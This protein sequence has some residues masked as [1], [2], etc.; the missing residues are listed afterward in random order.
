MSVSLPLSLALFL[1]LSGAVS[2][3]PSLSLTFSLFLCG[4]V[5]V[6]LSLS[7]SRSDSLSLSFFV[8][9]HNEELPVLLTQLQDMT[10]K[11]QA[12]VEEA[13]T[14]LTAVPKSAKA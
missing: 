10:P 12:C 5:S 8:S 9:P 13:R 14:I 2:I 6:S 11:V 3:Y 1:C 4:A 7:P